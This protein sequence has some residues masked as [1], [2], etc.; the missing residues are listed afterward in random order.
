VATSGFFPRNVTPVH[1][2]C[3]A[4]EHYY[5]PIAV[6]KCRV[7]SAYVSRSSLELS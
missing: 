7:A 1:L 2:A 3:R 5:G 4:G 6:C